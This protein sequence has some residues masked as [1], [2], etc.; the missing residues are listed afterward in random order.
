MQVKEIVNDTIKEVLEN[1]P[2]LFVVEQNISEALDIHLTI[3]GDELVNIS[4]CIDVSRKIEQALDRDEY[5]FSIKVQSSGADEPLKFLRQ[6]KKHV[7]RT[8]KVKT[9]TE[10]IEGKL[11]KV[12]N[13]SI[14]LS[15]K[16][17]EKKPVGKGKITINHEK[18]IS[19]Q[20]IEKANIKLTF[21]KN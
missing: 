20:D 8:F 5:D 21:N 10:K 19:Y 15:W 4:D 2:D 17:R 11:L 16:T 13:D 3:D 6:Y 12:E 7:G 1:R 9:S 18:A 14:I